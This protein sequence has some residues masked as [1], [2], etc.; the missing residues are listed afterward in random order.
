MKIALPLF[1]DKVCM[2]F[3][4]CEKFAFF[5]VDENS[6]LILLE[7]FIKNPPHQPDFL[8]KWLNEK[9]VNIILAGGMGI[10]AQKLFKN[11][12]IEVITGCPNKNPYIVVTDY[13]KGVLVTTDNPCD[14]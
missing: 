11:K 12:G 13:M 4:Y 1:S 5:E 10:R 7:K 2:H 14:H 6:G 8:P 3:G 9:G